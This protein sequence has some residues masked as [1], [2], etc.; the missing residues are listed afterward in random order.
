MQ[1]IF[2]QNICY[3]SS[4]EPDS[5]PDCQKK[6]KNSGQ[7]ETTIDQTRENDNQNF[8]KVLTR[9]ITTACFA[10]E[11]PLSQITNTHLNRAYKTNEEVT[12]TTTLNKALFQNSPENFSHTQKIQLSSSKTSN[13]GH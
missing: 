1:Q 9:T 7:D 5:T 13:K 6:K 11:D 4:H 10:R 2:G 8:G 12:G 3:E